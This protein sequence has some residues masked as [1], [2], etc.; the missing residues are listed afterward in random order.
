MTINIDVSTNTLG[1]FK[2]SGPDCGEIIADLCERFS[3]PNPSSFFMKQYGYYAPSRVYAVNQFGLFKAG[4]LFNVLAYLKSNY[5]SL[6]IELSDAAKEVV[7]D[8][9]PLFTFAKSNKYKGFV[10]ISTEFE[11]RP[12]QIEA[13]KSVIESG[14]GRCMF[15][16]PTASGKSFIIA[17]IIFTLKQQYKPTLRTLILVPSSQLVTQF[18]K[19]LLEYGFTKQEVMAF[20]PATIKKHK[21]TDFNACPIIISNR[22][23]LFNHIDKLKDFDLLIADEVQSCSPDSKTER[24]IKKLSAKLKIG[25]S[26][27]I[28]T[29]KLKF[30]NLLDVFGPVVF[31]ET[32]TNLQS[33]GY[34]PD[35]QFTLIKVTD[36]VVERDKS[37]LFNVKTNVRYSED[38]DIAFNAAYTAETEHMA[39]N[40]LQLYSP[41]LEQITLADGNSLILFDR[42][43]FGRALFDFLT[44]IKYNNATIYYI[45]GSTPVDTREEI[46]VKCEQNSDIIIVAQVAVMS[47]GINIKNLTNLIMT[48]SNKSHSRTIQS[49]GRLLR[50]HKD[51]TA[52]NV[53]DIVFYSYKY[54]KRHYLERKA[55]YKKHYHKTKPDIIHNITLD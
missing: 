46:R 18:S 17:N 10:N 29:D 12:Y 1:E 39:E 22:Q 42:I 55:L 52:A 26:G 6:R 2:I 21:L 20:T 7:N 49:I 53:Y 43:D 47:V 32:I 5:P 23:F 37:I 8:R 31:R 51:K 50:L 3:A 41:V 28:P 36:K 14:Y 25:C 16:S 4:L 33:E 24:L 30:W 45:D 35:A 48:G 11:P 9:L 15:E 38:N 13:I 40:C 19:D 27:T 54:S 44:D 34:L